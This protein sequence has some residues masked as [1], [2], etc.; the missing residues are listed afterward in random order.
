MSNVQK[1]DPT[2]VNHEWKW[3]AFVYIGDDQ[4]VIMHGPFIS[5]GDA[6]DYI[7]DR[8]WVGE[9]YIA[10]LFTKGTVQ[11]RSYFDSKDI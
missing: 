10:E 8:N 5:H 3:V 9:S 2:F 6:V 7:V 4:T 1:F 11:V